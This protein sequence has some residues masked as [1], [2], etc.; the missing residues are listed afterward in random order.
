MNDQD[1]YL[2]LKS[3]SNYSC[4]STRTLRDYISDPIDPLPSYCVKR[5][6]LVKKSEFDHWIKQHKTQILTVSEIAKEI[7]TS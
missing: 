7:I 5:K 2:D 3:L 4:L 1:K 6:I